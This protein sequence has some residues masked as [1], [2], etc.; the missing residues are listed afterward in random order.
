MRTLT[1]VC[2]LLFSVVTAWAQPNFVVIMTD[3]QDDTGSMNYMPKVHS[4]LAEHGITFT[5]SFVNFSLC[6]P[7]RASFL[8]GQAAHNHGVKSNSWRKGGGWPA[9]RDKE[10]NSLP[11]WLKAAGYQT[12]YIGK[13]LNGYLAVEPPKEIEE[14]PASAR[15]RAFTSH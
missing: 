5:N 9:F 8:T 1:T 13:Y 2:F 12:A 11:V 10:G 7:S 3:D 4:V 14:T 6:C 15:K